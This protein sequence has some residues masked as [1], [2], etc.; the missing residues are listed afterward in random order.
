MNHNSRGRK[1]LELLKSSANS[2]A[3]FTESNNTQINV[4]NE[5]YINR[6]ALSFDDEDESDRDKSYDELLKSSAT[7]ST[8]FIEANNTQN[9]EVLNEDHIRMI[10]DALSFDEEDVSDRDQSYDELLKSSATSS[11]TFIEA[12]NTQNNEVLNEDHI[13]MIRDALSFDEEDVSDRDQ[14]YDELLKSSAT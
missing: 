2:S 5:K 4:F 3:A 10:R 9:N 14:S 13:R 12:N 1:I 8:T 7:S 11:T 6:N